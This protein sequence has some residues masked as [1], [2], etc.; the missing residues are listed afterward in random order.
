MFI[1]NL[2]NFYGDFKQ[3]NE[4]AVCVFSWFANV[5]LAKTFDTKKIEAIKL[6]CKLFLT[7]EGSDRNFF[8]DII[9]L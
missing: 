5:Q 4:K 1:K 3:F 7:N 8:G 2:C 9:F 6:C